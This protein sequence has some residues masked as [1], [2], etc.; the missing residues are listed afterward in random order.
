IGR[1]KRRLALTS[2]MLNTVWRD[3]RD[4]HYG[5]LRGNE[6]LLY[7]SLTLSISLFPPLSLPHTHTHTHTHTHIPTPLL[8]AGSERESGRSITHTDGSLP[9]TSLSWAAKYCSV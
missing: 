8:S 6:N 2:I 3:P 9:G 5:G 1:L 7:I 4:Y